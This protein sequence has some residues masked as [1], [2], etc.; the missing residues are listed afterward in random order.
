[1]SSSACRQLMLIG[2]WL[3]ATAARLEGHVVETELSLSGNEDVGVDD[4]FEELFVD[5][6]SLNLFQTSS[7]D[8]EIYH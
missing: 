2:V 8:G 6:R 5:R 3:I 7:V 4:D 1:M